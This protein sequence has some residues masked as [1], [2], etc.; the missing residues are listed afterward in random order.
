[1]I[2]SSSFTSDDRQVTEVDAE[3]LGYVQQKNVDL[4]VQNAVKLAGTDAAK[5]R[6]TLQAAVGVTQRVGNSAMTRIL[7]NALNELNSSG[8]ISVGTRKTIALGGR[9]KTVKTGGDAFRLRAF[10]LRKTFAK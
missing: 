2:F 6:Q 1:M 3:V 10:R 4:M 5:A 8:T 7:Q 9:T